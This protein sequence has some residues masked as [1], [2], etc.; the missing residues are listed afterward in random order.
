MVVSV[1]GYSLIGRFPCLVGHPTR[2]VHT[3]P[4]EKSCSRTGWPRA[5]ANDNIVPNVSMLRRV[6][7][8]MTP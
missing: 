6:D 7:N 1:I 5:G 2:K 4:G 8:R 3:P